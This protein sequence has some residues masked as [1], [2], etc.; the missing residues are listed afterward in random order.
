MSLAGW[1][2]ALE[3]LQVREE[4][5]PVQ[6]A[7]M[8]CL[9]S[10]QGPSLLL[11]HGLLG[12]ADAWGAATQRL[13]T[14]STILAPDA[15]GIGGSDRVAGLDVSLTAAA[16]RVVALMDA[17]DIPQTDIVG[18]SHGGSIALMLAAR[19]PERVR[20]LILHAPANPFSDIADPLIRFYR[21]AL[22]RRFASRLP[23]VPAGMQSLA[24]GRMYGDASRVRSGSLESYIRSLRI[25]GTVDYV[26]SILDRWHEDMAELAAV[27]PKVRNVP[28][29]LLWGDRDRAVSLASGERLVGYFERAS[30]LV[31]PGAGHL[32]HEEVPAAFSVA[33]NS[34]LG[35]LK[36]EQ[37]HPS[38]GLRIVSRNGVA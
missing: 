36:R 37:I 14:D 34:F 16:E 2:N 21:T 9:V 30:L 26:L 18:T 10:G 31:I 28:A 24:L 7:R 19:H 1:I 22:G 23:A 20:S 27:L 11:L 8:R 3:Y 13:A 33:I 4:F 5:V 15:L 25:P 12:T 38:K 6:G 32:P 35:G 17:K 29:L